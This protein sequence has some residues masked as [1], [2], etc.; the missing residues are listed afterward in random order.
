M[1]PTTSIATRG[2]PS[3]EDEEPLFPVALIPGIGDVTVIDT[4][5]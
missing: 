5:R 1:V 2:E 4:S 3:Q